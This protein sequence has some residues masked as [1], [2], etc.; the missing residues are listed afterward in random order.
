MRKAT[1]YFAL[2]L[3]P[4]T[5]KLAKVNEGKRLPSP[6]TSQGGVKSVRN[7]CSFPLDVLFGQRWTGRVMRRVATAPKITALLRLPNAKLSGGAAVRLSAGLERGGA[8][9]DEHKKN[10]AL[11]A[12]TGC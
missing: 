12:A 11:C 4:P 1:I 8:A 9:N 6:G 7:H 10:S 3:M 2:R 5:Q